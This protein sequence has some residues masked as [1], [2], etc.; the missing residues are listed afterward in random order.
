MG[1]TLHSCART[2]AAMRKIQN[3]TSTKRFA[4]LSLF[5]C[6]RK[7]GLRY[8]YIFDY[9][10]GLIFCSCFVLRVCYSFTHDYSRYRPWASK[11]RLGYYSK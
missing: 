6:M 11:D 3:T 7:K 8:S 1:Q 5:V 9:W 10:D 4:L 2:M